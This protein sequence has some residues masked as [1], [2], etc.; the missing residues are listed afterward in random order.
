MD[1]A[2][3][4]LG[5][6]QRRRLLVALLDHNPQDDSPSVITGSD[7]DVDALEELVAMEHVHLPKLVEYGYI[8]WDREQREVSKG[9][10]FEEIR[11]LLDLLV[12]HEDELPQGW[13]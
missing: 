9:P 6:V 4:A 7:Q 13:L 12:E 5:H 10:E 8:T 2:L 1:D 3:D 11:P